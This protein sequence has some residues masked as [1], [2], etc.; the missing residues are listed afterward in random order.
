MRKMR[1]RYWK[2]PRIMSTEKVNKG[3]GGRKRGEKKRMEGNNV[4][5]NKE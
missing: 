5:V 1:D 3:S 2:V 4:F